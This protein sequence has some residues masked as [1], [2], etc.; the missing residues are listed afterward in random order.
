[1]GQRKALRSVTGTGRAKVTD[2]G[3]PTPTLCPSDTFTRACA[4]TAGSGTDEAGRMP[5]ALPAL[6]VC[7]FANFSAAAVEARASGLSAAALTPEPASA[8]APAAENW[9]A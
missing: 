5:D 3:I 4:S 1:M 8:E 7:P 9:A 6:W 2:I